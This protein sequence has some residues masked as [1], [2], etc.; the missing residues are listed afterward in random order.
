M[1]YCYYYQWIIVIITNELLLL[2]PPSAVIFD[3]KGEFTVSFSL[4]SYK[5]GYYAMVKAR[6]GLSQT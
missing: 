5:S 2:L 6:L 4:F 1:D 3:E